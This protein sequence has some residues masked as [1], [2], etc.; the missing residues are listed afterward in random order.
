MISASSALAADVPP[1]MPA[2][3]PVVVVP[4]QAGFDWKGPY[5]GAFLTVDILTDPFEV[6]ISAAGG[7]VGFNIVR[8]SFLF[9]PQ[10]RLGVYVPESDFLVA[11]GPRVGVIFG[12]EDRIL[13]YAAASFGWI[14][15][16]PDPGT[17][18]TFGGGVEVGLGERFSIFAEARAL[19]VPTIGCCGMLVTTGGNFHF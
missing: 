8:G 10:L 6:G 15:N 14:P 1:I 11:G 2:Q 12:A 17:L 13:V 3:P 5:A 4:P 19:G 18:Y 9:G 16:A 7:Q